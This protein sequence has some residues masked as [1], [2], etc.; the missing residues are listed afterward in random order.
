MCI[1]INSGNQLSLL[2]AILNP[3]LAGRLPCV[4]DYWPKGQAWRVPNGTAEHMIVPLTCLWRTLVL[5][6][7]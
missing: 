2:H 7:L 4:K 5:R 6:S 3:S 1:E